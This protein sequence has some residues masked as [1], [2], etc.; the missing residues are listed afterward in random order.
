MNASMNALIIT[1]TA[2]KN[3]HSSKTTTLMLVVML[4]NQLTEAEKPSVFLIIMLKQLTGM[5]G[6]QIRESS[7]LLF[8][9]LQTKLLSCIIN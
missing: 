9:Y 1:I 3:T 7:D 6:D 8:I 5:R 4:R 2:D